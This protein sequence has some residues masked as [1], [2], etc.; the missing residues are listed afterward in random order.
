MLGELINACPG[1]KDDTVDFA[2]VE[3]RTG[4]H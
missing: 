1:L 4:I 2:F 3:H